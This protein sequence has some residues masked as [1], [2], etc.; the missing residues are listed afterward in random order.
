MKKK[1][2]LV[3]DDEE[4]ILNFVS[5]VLNDAN[6]TTFTSSNVKD[7]L[8]VLQKNRI[9]LILLDIMLPEIDGFSFNN[10]LKSDED[11]KNIPVAFITARLDAQ[12]KIIGLKEG[13]IDYICKPFTSD[14]L[15]KRVEQIFKKVENG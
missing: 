7:A 4:D 12:D 14:E 11:L 9:D 5:M 6:F 13:A 10:M 3:I 2:I 1:K 8:L 15:I